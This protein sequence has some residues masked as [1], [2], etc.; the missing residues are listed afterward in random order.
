MP[1]FKRKTG[2]CTKQYTYNFRILAQRLFSE[3]SVIMHAWS[4]LANGWNVF[5]CGKQRQRE[6]KQGRAIYKSK[7]HINPAIDPRPPEGR[8]LRQFTILPP[9]RPPT[10][11]RRPHWEERM[12]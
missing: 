3:G 1:R 5:G 11:R 4:I 7:Q 10:T 6:S 9:P 8:W 12:D 2:D